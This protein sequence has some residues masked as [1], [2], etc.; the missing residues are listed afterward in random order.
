MPFD[1]KSDRLLLN[2]GPI[3]V[4]F[5]CYIA[6]VMRRQVT[7]PSL[8]EANTSV[9]IDLLHGRALSV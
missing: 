8:R 5:C 3:R 4:S 7:M 1:A 9:R 2:A 6:A